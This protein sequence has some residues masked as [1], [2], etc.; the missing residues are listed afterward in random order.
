MRCDTQSAKHLAIMPVLM[1]Q[2]LKFQSFTDGTR[3]LILEPGCL[4][5]TGELQTD[6][7]VEVTLNIAVALPQTYSLRNLHRGLVKLTLKS[8]LIVLESSVIV[9]GLHQHRQ[10][11]KE[12]FII[13]KPYLV[14]ACLVKR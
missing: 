4:N 8:F 14:I 3:H 10:P 13:W 11:V 5:L 2:C 7:L 9:G 12:S 1:H 6:V